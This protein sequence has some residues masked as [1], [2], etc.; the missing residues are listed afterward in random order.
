MPDNEFRPT[1]REQELAYTAVA[2]ANRDDAEEA[3]LDERA[4]WAT[5]F[6]PHIAEYREEL[7]KDFEDFANQLGA[8]AVESITCDF[9]YEKLHEIIAKCRGSTTVGGCISCDENTTAE[10]QLLA[11]GLDAL[12]RKEKLAALDAFDAGS[13]TFGEM[14]RLVRLNNTRALHRAHLS[15]LHPDLTRAELQAKE[16]EVWHQSSAGYKSRLFS[17]AYLLTH[18][19]TDER[20]LTIK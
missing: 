15:I 11:K 17:A 8:G 1:R 19:R 2:C 10:Q 16:Q 4:T 9:G 6:A 7:L 18:G 3:V 12:D 13:L 14:D 5:D 20:L